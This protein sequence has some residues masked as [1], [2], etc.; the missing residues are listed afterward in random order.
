MKIE[1]KGVTF[2]KDGDVEIYR[3]G[4]GCRKWLSLCLVVMVSKEEV[5]VTYSSR[6]KYL[7]HMVNG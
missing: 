6:K 4:V 7:P 1:S 5:K 3:E 2:S